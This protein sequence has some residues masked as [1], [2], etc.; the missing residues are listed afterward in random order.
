[1]DY[2]VRGEGYRFEIKKFKEKQT[3]KTNKHKQFF[4]VVKEDKTI[5]KKDNKETEI[6]EMRDHLE[7]RLGMSK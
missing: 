5:T 1:M 3:N 4:T 6:S 2:S 7:I